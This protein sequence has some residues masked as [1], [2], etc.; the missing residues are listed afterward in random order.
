MNLRHCQFLLMLLTIVLALAASTDAADK[1]KYRWLRK[2]PDID[3]ISI[4]GN[5][6]LST[7]TIRSRMYSRTR[8]LWRVLQGDR[9]SQVQ[10]ETLGRDTLEIKFLYF[11]RGYLGVKVHEEFVPVRPGDTASPAI[12]R[13]E[14]DE[15]RL[16][17]LG[18]IIVNGTFEEVFAGYFNDLIDD[19]DRGDPVNPFLLQGIADSMKTV[20]ANRGYPYATVAHHIDTTGDPEACPINY[21]VFADSLV[22]FG[23]VIITGAQNFPVSAARR[24]LKIKP[25]EIYRRKDI[26]DSQRRLF[27]SGYYTT[28]TLRPSES[29]GDR[30]QPDF[31][32]SLRER[33]A[34]ALT[35][36]IGA[37][38]AENID[39]QFDASASFAKRNLWGSRR[40]DLLADYA[41]KAGSDSRLVEHTYRL[42]F[43]EPWFIGIRM[44][45]T[46][47]GEVQPKLQDVVQDFKKSS[48]SVSADISRW[49]SQSTRL[50]VGTEYQSVTLSGI[51][52]DA[53]DSLKQR[54]GISA[55]RK[56][57]AS[58]RRDTR[59]D[60]FIPRHG[61]VTEFSA[62]YFGGFLRGD[63]DFYKLRAS[64]SRYQSA[65]PGW[66]SATRLQA[67]WAREFGE[68]EAV[69][70]DEAI[71]LGGAGTV[72][73][74][75]ENRLGPLQED[76]SPTGNRYNLV[77]N[78]EFR[79]RTIQILS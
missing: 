32:L 6:A 30:L 50:Q 57:Y 71:Y 3:S 46:L 42:R 8:N 73:G 10:R 1:V 20:L 63:A 75:E 59:D 13:V 9:R 39:L 68:T 53:I 54:E 28:F 26:L 52:D 62:E 48:W 35:F 77:F 29:S 49:L 12:V 14:I 64:W 47:T 18:Q 36:T 72:R 17:R 27:E 25:G 2:T 15:G 7:S 61:S 58:L 22:H 40:A 76:G 37:G 41:L 67:A 78:Q 79:W 60:L 69:P 38:Q 55:R 70:L 51:P 45:L 33:K 24:E 44:P 65:W 43:T 4:S 56:L 19:V 11:S 34:R 5:D 31:E 66:I 21:D 23:E 74:F 16:F